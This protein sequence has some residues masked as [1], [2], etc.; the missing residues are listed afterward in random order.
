MASPDNQHLWSKR[1]NL[2]LLECMKNIIPLDDSRGFKKTLEDLDWN[3]VAFGQFSGEMC[4]QKWTKISHC[5]RKSRTLSELLLEASEHV[6]Q[7]RRSKAIEKHPDFPKR[8]LT[9]YLRF[10]KEHLEKYSQMY[11]KYNNR[12]LTKILAE[13]YK[14]LP[15]E[16]KDRYIQEFQKEKQ[17]FPEKLAKFKETHPGIEHYKKY[18]VPKSH[19]TK[20]PKKSQGDMKNLKS[21]LETE[22]PKTFSTVIKFQGEPKKPPINAYHKFHQDSWSSTE[23]QHLPLRERWVEISRRWHQVPGSLREHYNCQVEEL[24]K[25]YW[26]EMDLWLK[27]LSPEEATAYREAK[28][29]CGKRKNLAMSGG[30]SP[31]FGQTEQQSTSATEELQSSS[32]EMQG[33]LLPETDSSETIQ[34]YDGGSQAGGQ[35]MMENGKEEDPIGSSDSSSCSSDSSSCSSDSSSCSSD[36]SSSSLDSAS[37]EDEDEDDGHVP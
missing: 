8:P 15:Q 35:N 26:V 9:A 2:K 3:K 23:L 20:V 19:Q 4:R 33:L 13:K 24:Q 12:Q 16:I 17:E 31:K 5:L 34:G 37:S 21:P 36:S 18:R 28:A 25:Q 11:P 32:G 22:F 6:K 29:T 14:Q 1:D 7:S 30:R 27:G 10:Y